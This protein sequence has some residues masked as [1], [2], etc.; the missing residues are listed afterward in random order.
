MQHKVCQLQ[1]AE[2]SCSQR[3]PFF[4]GASAGHA[5][6]SQRSRNEKIAVVI[7]QSSFGD[8]DS[9]MTRADCSEGHTASFAPSSES[10]LDAYR[11]WWTAR[12]TEV[13]TCLH[14]L[15]GHSAQVCAVVALGAN[16][17]VS[18]SR[19]QTLRVWDLH[20]GAVL[21]TLEGHKDCVSAVA[22][23]DAER[24]VSGSGDSTLKVWNVDTG[25]C[26][27]TIKTQPDDAGD[28]DTYADIW[29]VAVLGVARDR[30][31]CGGGMAGDVLQVWSLSSGECL[32]ILRGHLSWVCAVAA[33]DADRCV[34]A[35]GDATLRV[36]SA[37]QGTCLRTLRGHAG[38]VSAVVVLDTG[39]VVSG[40]RDMTVRVW[41][42]ESGECMQTLTGH[43]DQ[44]DAVAAL[45]ADRVV[46]GG[47]DETLKVWSLA[48]GVCL[49]TLR[50]HPT[51]RRLASACSVAV[52]DAERV[53][54]GGGDCVVNISNVTDV[55]RHIA[56]LQIHRH[57]RNAT[58][59]PMY[60]L[61][62]RWLQRNLVHECE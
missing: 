50:G 61:C 40:S 55:R 30:V 38:E 62:R 14:K 57:W 37:T 2:C 17:A 16:R 22:V 54:S 18:A 60:E 59:N 26:I 4:L 28:W 52:V 9:G 19:D 24:V 48:S 39:R 5:K 46:S 13:G 49:L 58:S 53:A 41:N 8:D 7:C 10:E 47:R 44:V 31:V 56:A 27:K 3:P 1:A 11:R 35:S 34:S 25:D 29:T 45:D 21:Q 42:L 32:Q 15:H 36:W 23:L 51:E 6:A 43:Q 20:S 12:P 33:L